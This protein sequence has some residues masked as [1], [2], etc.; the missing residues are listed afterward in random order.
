[1]RTLIIIIAVALF[2]G[3]FPVNSQ[4]K[5]WENF[6][7][8]MLD[9]EKNMQNLEKE[10][11][12]LD[13][14]DLTFDTCFQMT[15]PFFIDT[16]RLNKD[17]QP[18]GGN[19]K[20]PKNLFAE[21]G[22]AY[23][24]PPLPDNFK[25]Y[26]PSDGFGYYGFGDKIDEGETQQFAGDLFDKLADIKGVEV[27]YISKAVL[28]LMPNMDLKMQGTDIG[29]VAGKLDGLQIFSTEERSAKNTLKKETDKL[30]KDGRYEVIMMVKDDDSKTAFYLKRL[31]N[32]QSEL[33]MVTEEAFTFDMSVIRLMGRFTV[34]DIQ[35]LTKSNKGKK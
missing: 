9:I 28:G 34:Q 26:S 19:I 24:L 10:L 4:I 32:Q 30:L 18:F 13:L 12:Q 22:K 35:N 20:I 11:K 27:V 7:M 25:I 5:G 33:L 6:N 23:T 15:N 2:G 8:D 17:W 21:K 16:A 31:G 1:M 14:K 3:T 29:N